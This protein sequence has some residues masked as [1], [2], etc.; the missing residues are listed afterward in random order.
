[1]KTLDNVSFFIEVAEYLAN[2]NVLAV[3]GGWMTPEK[4]VL[5]GDY[6]RIRTLA[7]D[8]RSTVLSLQS[9]SHSQ[10]M[11]NTR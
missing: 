6:A 9:T 10:S 3:G 11:W 1:M 4:E 8:A 7:A 2:D 5:A